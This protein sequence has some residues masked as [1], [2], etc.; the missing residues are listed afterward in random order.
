M[1]QAACPHIYPAPGHAL[2]PAPLDLCLFTLITGPRCVAL[3]DLELGEL[4]LSLPPNAGL[5]GEHQHTQPFYYFET[6]SH[7][8]TR[9]GISHAPA[10]TSFCVLEL[11]ACVVRL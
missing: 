1:S 5:E 8:T 9:A 4:C 2:V 3:A 11:Q 7:P 10:S 6:V